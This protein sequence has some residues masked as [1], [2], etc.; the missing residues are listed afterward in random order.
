MELFVKALQTRKIG[1]RQLGAAIVWTEN[2]GF[3]KCGQ[4]DNLM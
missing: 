4:L 2:G 3:R 1:K